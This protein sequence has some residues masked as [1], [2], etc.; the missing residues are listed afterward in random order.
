MV[1]MISSLPSS[2]LTGRQVLRLYNSYNI[3][4]RMQNKENI[5]GNK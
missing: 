5:K 2:R 1:R 4:A 3:I